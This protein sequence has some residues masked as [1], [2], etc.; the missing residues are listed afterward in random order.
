MKQKMKTILKQHLPCIKLLAQLP[1]LHFT[2]GHGDRTEVGLAGPSLW[3]D[4]KKINSV[5][6][7]WIMINFLTYKLWLWGRFSTG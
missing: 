3:D 1:D 5:T 2:L 4:R 7:C 6:C